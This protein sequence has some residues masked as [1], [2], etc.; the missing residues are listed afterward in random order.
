MRRLSAGHYSTRIFTRTAF[1]RWF[2]AR[3]AKVGNECCFS[4]FHVNRMTLDQRQTMATLSDGQ[5][6]GRYIHFCFALD[7]KIVRCAVTVECLERFAAKRALARD[8]YR[9][10]F[11]L[12]RSE[13]EALALEKFLQGDDRPLVTSRDIST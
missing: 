4:M 6:D 12:Y 3:L 13:I 9:A 1:L 10:T 7:S 8:S 11:G 2:A 5:F